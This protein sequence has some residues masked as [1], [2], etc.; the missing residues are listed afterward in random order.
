MP[1]YDFSDD[2]GNII[3]CLAARDATTVDVDGVVYTK[4]NDPTGFAMPGKAVGIKPQNEQVK[5]GYY[6]ME[7]EK[8]SRFLDRS[9]FSTKQ[10]KK[11]WGF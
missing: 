5:E 2:N 8:G 9:T 7:C 6:N 11:A 4:T 10:I 3:E 1:L